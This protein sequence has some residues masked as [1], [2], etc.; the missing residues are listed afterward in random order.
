MSPGWARYLLPLGEALWTIGWV[1]PRLLL[2]G[3]LFPS[4]RVCE[5]LHSPFKRKVSI[6]HSP[7][8]V[9]KVN[10][11]SLYN[12]TFLGLLFTVQ[13]PWPGGPMWG[14]NPMLLGE[15]CTAAIIF[16]LW[17]MYLGVRVLILPRLHCSPHPQAVVAS[18]LYVYLWKTASASIQ[19]VLNIVAL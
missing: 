13:D 14:L 2:N 6:P 18:A 1:W 11:I 3:C 8:A 7:L 12:K 19:V 17:I 5:S 10:P 9:L 16:L 15:T 4:P